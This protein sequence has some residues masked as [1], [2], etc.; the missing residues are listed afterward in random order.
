MLLGALHSTLIPNCCSIWDT[1]SSV[2]RGIGLGYVTPVATAAKWYPDRK[3]L[4]TGI[5][6]MGFGVGAFLLSIVL[7]PILIVRTDGDLPL[8]FHRSRPAVR[9]NSASRELFPERYRPTG[10]RVHAGGGVPGDQQHEVEPGSVRQC[11]RSREFAIMW[12]VFFFNIAAGISVISF[13]RRCFRMFGDWPIP[14]S[15]RERSPGM[16]Q[17]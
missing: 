6:V 15:S 12:L 2:V 4:A 14:Q 13:S 5:V 1:A 9:D 10:Y 3:G 11:I 16:E 8:V 7:A 17:P